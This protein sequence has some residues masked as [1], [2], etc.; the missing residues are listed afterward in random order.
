M[1]VFAIIITYNGEP[2]IKKCLQSISTSSFPAKIV[3]IDNASTD[4]TIE[5]IKENFTSITVIQ[6][7]KNLGF[8]QA[9]NIGLRLAL[10]E[11]ADYVFLLNQDAWIKENTLKHLIEIADHHQEYGILS[12]FHLDRSEQKLEQLFQQFLS[13][14]YTPEIV[15]DMYI[16]QLK[17]VYETNYVHAASWLIS[18]NCIKTVGGFD[19]IYFHYGE[20]DDY[21]QRTKFFRFK[22]GL[23]PSAIVV[24]DAVYKSWELMEWDKS[25]N[26]IVAYQHL[27]KMSPHYRSNLL[28]FFK[29]G[30]DE[31]TTLLL[32]RKFKKFAFRFSILF[33]IIL[34]LRKVQNSYKMSFKKGAFLSND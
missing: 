32:L 16:G 34:R 24:H 10:K 3:V 33:N 9:N 17:P 30:F 27:K 7:V 18:A 15:S 21:L 13:S 26:K 12:P 8:G 25:R 22:I 5:I 19:P 2:W 4:N 20:D 11:N 14:A 28:T 1:T 6:N 31:M 23:V 29:N